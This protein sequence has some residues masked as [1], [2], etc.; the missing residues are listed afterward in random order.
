[1][2]STN[3]IYTGLSG[4]NANARNIDVIGNN[5]ANVNTTA[6]K[7][8]RAL[9]STI[10]PR[11]INIGTAPG[12]ATGGTNPYQV[13]NGVRVAGVQRNMAAA[14]TN[15]TGN[16]G[17]MAVDGAGFF[18]VR[19]GT[20]TLYTRAGAFSPDAN[21]SM[22]N[23]SGDVLQGYGI[24][25]QFNIVA[26][27]LT[28][29]TIPVGE[30]KLAQASSVVKFTGNLNAQGIPPTHG[31]LI[32]LGGTTTTGLQ[33]VASAAPTPPDVLLT[34]SLL[35]SIEDPLLPAS[36]TPLFSAGQTLQ[37]RGASKGGKTVPP[38][39]LSITATSTVADLQT[40]LS[41]TLG[42]STTAGANPDGK[43]PGVTLNTQ[44]GVLSVVSNSGSV[45]DLTINASDLRLLDSSGNLVR[46][47]FAAAKQA[48]ADGESVRTGVIV[49]DSLGGEVGLDVSMVLDSKDS[50]GT[51]WR[52]YAESADDSDTSTA[53]ATGVIRFDTDGQPINPTPVP[54]TI[55]LAGTGAATPLALNLDF[56]S[57]DNGLTSLADDRSDFAVSFR[58]GAP[59]GVLASY[60]VGRDGVI[61]GAFTNGLNRPLGQVAL[62]NFTNPQGLEEI[63]NNMFIPG[64]NSG[65][66]VVTTPGNQGTGDITAGALEL[67]NVD[68]S[69]EFIKMIVSSTGYSASS[70]VIRTAD[71]LLQQLMVIGR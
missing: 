5:I 31:A 15:A 59:L 20:Q 66:P 7:S 64:A 42:I 14:S 8:S 2:P 62:A 61:T 70:R 6:F 33:S 24:D 23:I 13:G 54:I 63:G 32:T 12:D 36:G 48:T 30:L 16:A 43:A 58:D 38:A 49:Y 34:T 1:M 68:L 46:F 29:V 55:D 40:F 17:D 11:T 22:A 69:E 25:S 10:L 44:T 41:D 50:T 71:E 45:N 3:A 65:T 51:T 39:T 67:S 21:N 28:D 56:A 47:P 9:F 52:Y 53:L 4:L 18:M 19:K 37:L 35:T 57:T 27:K 60:G 26:G